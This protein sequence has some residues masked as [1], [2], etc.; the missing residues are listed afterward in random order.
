MFSKSQTTDV[1]NPGLIDVLRNPAFFIFSLSVIFSQVAFNMMNIVLIFQAF[2]L[3]GSSLAVSFLILAITIP[4]A[5]FSF[6]GG[7]VG[8][9][10]NKRFILI[11]GNI[12]RALFVIG[13][14]FFSESLAYLY[15]AAFLISLTTQ[16]YVPAETPIIP[17]IVKKNYLLAANSLFGVFLFGSILVGYVM[18]G[19]LLKFFGHTNNY[20][21]IGA[22]FLSATVFAYLIPNIPTSVKIGFTQKGG[23]KSAKKIIGLVFSEFKESISIVNRNKGVGSAVVFLALAQVITLIMATIIPDFAVSHL[24]IDAE[25][26]SLVIFAPAALGMIFMALFIGAYFK[27][28]SGNSLMN[29]G[30]FLSASVLLLLAL[31]PYQSLLLPIVG[32]VILAFFAGVANALIFVPSQTIIQST[33]HD[34]YRSKIYGLIFT[35]A[36]V[37]VLLPIVLTGLFADIFGAEIILI[38]LSIFIFLVGIRRIKVKERIL[39]I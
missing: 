26:M 12:L 29:L 19:P 37:L 28:T 23:L 1:P 17:H 15:L 21:F 36:G 34:S 32:T 33:V 18:G 13:F 6:L 20:L 2:K 38:A 31:I 3:T 35:L 4:Q 25:D 7:I 8:D 14:F 39:K 24:A 10:K 16:F 30:I 27:K 5:L 11:I 22:L 9:A